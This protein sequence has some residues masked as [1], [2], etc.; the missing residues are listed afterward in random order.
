MYEKFRIGKSIEKESRVIAR[1][2]AEEEME[3]EY[4]ISM[5]Y[6]AGGVGNKKKFETRER[7]CI[8]YH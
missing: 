5:G 4:L 8:Q 1:G 7:W 2:Q 3:S 6:S